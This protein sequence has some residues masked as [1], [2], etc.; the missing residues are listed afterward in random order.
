MLD[1]ITQFGSGLK[2]A[3][4]L[5]SRRLSYKLTFLHGIVHGIGNA[6]GATSIAGIV[7]AFLLR[8]VNFLDNPV[9]NQYIETNDI[10]TPMNYQGVN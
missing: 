7:I 1:G 5:L 10:N 2:R 3:N 9:I 6:I 4:D 8:F